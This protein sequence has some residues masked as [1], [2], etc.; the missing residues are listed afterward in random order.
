[1]VVERCIAPQTWYEFCVYKKKCVIY[2]EPRGAIGNE[3]GRNGLREGPEHVWN[4]LKATFDELK[5]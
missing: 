1:M 3:R 2:G 4:D 5:L